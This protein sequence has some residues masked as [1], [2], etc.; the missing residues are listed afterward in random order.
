M[1]ELT[2]KE[3][4]E[5]SLDVLHFLDLGIKKYNTPISEQL[6]MV[7][8]MYK[9]VVQNIKP[10]NSF[11]QNTQYF[12][13]DSSLQTIEEKR[14]FA[15]EKIRQALIS[16]PGDTASNVILFNY[17]LYLKGYKSYIVL[18]ESKNQRGE[19]HLSSLVEVGKDDWYFF[20]PSLERVNF[21]EDQYEVPEDFSYNWAGLG[22]KYYSKFYRP[23]STIKE[24]GD[25][26][27]PI[28]SHNVSEDSLLRELV[29]SI[30]KKIPDL[31]YRAKT[32]SIPKE[33][34]NASI[35]KEREKE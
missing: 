7:L 20:D 18:S 8:K 4:E 10:L 5:R 2:K 31:T 21:V 24:V 14:T 9:Y 22:M 16:N 25:E 1:K 13:E 15:F 11:G 19:G 12:S 17:L 32:I 35:E 29:E 33:R 23:V 30:G 27:I 6:E 28:S 3:V 26:E 34:D